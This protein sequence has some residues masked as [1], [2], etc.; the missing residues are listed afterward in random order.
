M[1]TL[2]D[3]IEYSTRELPA[4]SDGFPILREVYPAGFGECSSGDYSLFLF[5]A[6]SRIASAR[7]VAA[8][9]ESKCSAMMRSSYLRSSILALL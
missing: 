5:L 4:S 8:D 6:R 3:Y 9:H 7:D 2:I 1:V